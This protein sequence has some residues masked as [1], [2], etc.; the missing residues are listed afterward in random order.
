MLH[1]KKRVSAQVVRQVSK[2]GCSHC[3]DKSYA[4]QDRVACTLDLDAKDTLNPG[5]SF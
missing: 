4:P 5:A 2:A 1:N 3:P